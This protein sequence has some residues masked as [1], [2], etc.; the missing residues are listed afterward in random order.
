MTSFTPKPWYRSQTIWGGIAAIGSGL[1]GL[2]TVAAE[3][4]GGG[5]LNADTLSIAITALTSGISAIGG[6]LSVRGR[7]KASQPIGKPPNA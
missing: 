5:G 7:V 4:A 2:A 6:A 1:A 3:M